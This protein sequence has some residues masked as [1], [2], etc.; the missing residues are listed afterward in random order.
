MDGAGSQLGPDLNS[1]G[2][3]R[4]TREL[5]RSLIDPDAEIVD[6]NRFARVVTRGGETIT[7]RL[8]NQDSFSIQLF[9]AKERLLSFMKSDLRGLRDA[10]ELHHA[11]ISGYADRRGTGRCRQLPPFSERQAMTGRG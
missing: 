9:D 1:V 6:D 4:R 7:G 8:L 3:L 11:V 10:Q 5:Q 2:P